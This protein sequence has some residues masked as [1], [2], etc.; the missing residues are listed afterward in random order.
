MSVLVIIL[1]P[2]ISETAS[3]S[4]SRGE[5]RSVGKDNIALG[6]TPPLWAIQH[7]NLIEV[8]AVRD[9]FVLLQARIENALELLRST[10][11]RDI[12]RTALRDLKAAIVEAEGLLDIKE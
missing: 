3:P 1:F 9:D 12:R 8:A 4:Q 11:E 5:S 6:M 2:T 7:Q 10:S